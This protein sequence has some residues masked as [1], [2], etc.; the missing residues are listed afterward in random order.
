MTTQSV[1]ANNLIF[2]TNL[3][4][5]SIKDNFVLVPQSYYEINKSQFVPDSLDKEDALTEEDVKDIALAREEFKRGEYFTTAQV[6][7]KH[8]L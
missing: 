1:I 7:Q 2:D 8:G 4:D 5:Y 3:F 6:K